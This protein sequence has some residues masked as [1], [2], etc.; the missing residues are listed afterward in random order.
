MQDSPS[1]A[2]LGWVGLGGT[3]GYCLPRDLYATP[4]MPLDS[5]LEPWAWLC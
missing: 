2:V 5:G 3:S 1:W 4:L